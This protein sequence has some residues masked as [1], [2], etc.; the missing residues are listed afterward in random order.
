MRDD[1]IGTMLVRPKLKVRKQRAEWVTER[2]LG[3]V[4]TFIGGGI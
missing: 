1:V 3:F 2:M 4:E